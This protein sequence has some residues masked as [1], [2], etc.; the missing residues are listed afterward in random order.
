MKQV[1]EAA[2][3]KVVG[4]EL[5]DV[6]A[7]QQTEVDGSLEKPNSHPIESGFGPLMLRGSAPRTYGPQV[8]VQFF[9]ANTIGAGF[10]CWEQPI[11]EE[12]AE[13]KLIACHVPEENR[14]PFIEAA[15]TAGKNRERAVRALNIEAPIQ[16]LG[17]VAKPCLALGPDE[18]RLSKAI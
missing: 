13:Q 18:V 12:V 16:H 15:A 5:F 11:L 2:L 17:D 6:G 9:R 1:Q 14:S 3:W 4:R 7:S 10:V 8:L